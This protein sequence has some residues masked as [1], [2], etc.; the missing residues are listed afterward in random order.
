MSANELNFNVKSIGTIQRTSQDIVLNI[1]ETYRPA[2]LTLEHYSHVIVV[3][4]G[5]QLDSD[6]YR[7]TL[8]THPPYAEEH[9]T[10][11]FATRSPI[12]PNPIL[13]TTCKIIDMD[14][15]AGL[16]KIE[17][18]DAFDGTPILDLKAYYPVCERVR[19]AHIPD[20]L[21]DWPE[22]MPEEGIGLMPH[23]M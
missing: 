16:I 11:I 8:K 1:D 23:E 13:M 15:E 6:E 3:W 7:Q 17:N 5:D 22:W 9:L 19:E 12:R 4:W 20:W 2:L 21:V 10:G 18:I 14:Q